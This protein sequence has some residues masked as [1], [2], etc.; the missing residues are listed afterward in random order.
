MH[1]QGIF[2]HMF[3]PLMWQCLSVYLEGLRKTTKRLAR[4]VQPDGL[5]WNMSS[6]KMWTGSE[7]VFCFFFFTFMWPC[8]VTN[9]FIII[10]TRC[11]NFLNLLRHETLYV[12][13]NSSAH[14]Q[15]F[16]HCTH[17]TGIYRTGLKT[18]FEQDLV[19]FESC[20]QTCMTYTSAECTIN[21]LLMMGRGTARNI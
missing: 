7:N 10:P 17:G 12:S 1:A 8:I 5:Y 21:K 2:P 4:S 18:A 6:N 11:T 15:D 3:L 9:F 16:I 14:H 20:L 13:G 19:L